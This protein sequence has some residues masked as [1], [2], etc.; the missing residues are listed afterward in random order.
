VLDKNPKKNL[1]KGIIEVKNIF[2]KNAINSILCDKPFVKANFLA[3]LI[4]TIDSPII[5]LDFDLLYSGYTIAEI[6]S[7]EKNVMLLRPSKDEWFQ[8]FKMVLLK[9]SKEKT[10]VIIDSLNGLF[11]LLEGEDVGRIVNASIMLLGCVARQSKSVILF[12]SI[13]NRKKD[14]DWILS[15]T[16]RHIVDAR[17]MTKVY[18]KNQGPHVLI[19]V[20]DD[21]YDITN[22]IKVI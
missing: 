19:D 6:F 7:I 15:P 10:V 18:L 13:T 2:E 5:Y 22:S 1:S 14:G 21:G 9:V 4:K 11:N 17:K 8:M 16:G 20:L 12:A 3:R